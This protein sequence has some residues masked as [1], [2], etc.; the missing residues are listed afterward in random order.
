MELS[1]ALTAGTAVLAAALF[2]DARLAAGRRAVAITAGE[3]WLAF[4]LP[5]ASGYKEH[6]ILQS[7]MV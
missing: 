1:S 4:G 2:D 5:R 6:T 7:A 3:D